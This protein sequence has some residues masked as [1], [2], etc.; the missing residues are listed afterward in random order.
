MS[1]IDQIILDAVD[2]QDLPFAVAMVANSEEVLWEGSAGQANASKPASL[3]T[4]FRLFSMTKAV[5]SLAAMMMIDRGKATLDTAVVDVLP[6][7]NKL[8]VLESMGPDGPVYRAPRR[9]VTLRHLLT[10][11][12]GVVYGEYNT[13]MLEYQTTMGTPHIFAGT[14]ESMNYPLMF[15][16]GDEWAYG[17]GLDWAG[18]IVQ[19]LDGRTIDRFCREEIF[20]PL[21]MLDTAFEADAR[22]ENLA[23]VVVRGPDERFTPMELSAP[24]QPEIYG[25]GSALYGTAPDYIRFLRTVLNRGELDGHRVISPE[26]IEPM[27]VNQI[28]D[29]SLPVMKSLA[30]DI[31]VDVE[32]FPGYRKTHTAGFVRMEAAVPGM[33]SVGSLTWAGVCNTHYWIDPAKDLTAVLMTQS[34]PFCEPRFMQ[35]YEKFEREVYRKFSA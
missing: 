21:G 19:Q 16:P 18:R 1:E 10:H 17:I 5:G 28:G 24:S 2:R 35:V 32:L 20:A 34:L 15:D 25:M 9:P 14:L 3:E 27:F 29:M 30:Q 26:A 8:L 23:D 31:A 4:Y 12:S 22:S 33:R 7:F 6:E 11:T 13:K